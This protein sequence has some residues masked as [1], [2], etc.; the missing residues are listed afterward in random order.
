M[1]NPLF[2]CE[3]PQVERIILEP[4]EVQIGQII[5]PI[6]EECEEPASSPFNASNSPSR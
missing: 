3:L 1:A 6:P 2:P 4:G 5:Y